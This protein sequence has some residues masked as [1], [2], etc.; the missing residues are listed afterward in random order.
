MT[1]AALTVVLALAVAALLVALLAGSLDDLL[2]T[3]VGW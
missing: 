1:V 2:G 3:G